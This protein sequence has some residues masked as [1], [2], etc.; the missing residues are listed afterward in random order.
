MNRLKAALG[1]SAS[2]SDEL[3]LHAEVILFVFNE[4]VMVC[5][6]FWLTRKGVTL[7]IPFLTIFFHQRMKKALCFNF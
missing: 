5:N 1:A 4:T 2:A 3:G 6:L 7:D